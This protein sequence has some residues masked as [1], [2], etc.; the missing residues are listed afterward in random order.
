M[1]KSAKGAQFERALC[2]RLSEWW[3]GGK[4]Q[5]VFWRSACS[6]G[7]ATNRA[8]KGGA[9]YGQHG[10]IQAVDPVGKPLMDIFTIELKR[11]YTK[12]SFVDVFDKPSK[13]AQSQW[14]AFMEQ[15]VR[16]A[17]Q[18]GSKHWMLIQRR[19]RREALV[20]IPHAAHKAMCFKGVLEA[21]G[22]PHGTFTAHVRLGKK[23]TR[24][25]FAVYTLDNFL[26]HAKPEHF[27]L[28]LK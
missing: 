16:S 1:G 22:C 19:D 4:R 27:H 8:K 5:D 6:G 23:D 11:G 7:M 12:A 14:E 10:D 17:Q 28:L 2:K 9:A 21:K 24:M 26:K 15:A 18:A 3:T 25:R 20:F 13:C